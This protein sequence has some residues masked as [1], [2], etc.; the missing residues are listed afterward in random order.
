MDRSLSRIVL[1]VAFA[2][3][4]L[5]AQ[6]S[7]PTTTAI[8][9]VTVIDV[10]KG[11][12]RPALTVVVEGEK[13]ARI[14][15]VA[16]VRPPEGA[17]IVNG[18][19]MFLMPGLIDAHVHYVDP[20][21]FGPLHVANGVVL[22]R[23]M[24]ND[25]GTAIDLRERTRRH[26]L[27]GPELVVTGAIID[28][29][30]PVWP[31]SEACTTAE[32][33]RAAVR[34]LVGAGVDQLKVYSRL[35]RDA[36]FAILDEAKKLGKKAVGHVPDSVTLEEAVAAGQASLEHLIGFE[37]IF[38]RLAGAP[39]ATSF[40]MLFRQWEHYPKADR[41]ALAK[42][43]ED[44]RK[45]G[46]VICPTLVVMEGIVSMSDPK[47]ANDP[48]QAYIPKPLKAFWE[49]GGYRGMAAEV[50]RGSPM[51][52]AF[53]AELHKAGV[54]LVCGTD[55]ANPNVIA[56]FSLHREMQIFQ[57]A[58]IPS[59]AVLECATLESA[60]LLGVADRLG[61]IAER[62]TA[63]MVLVRKNPLENVD[64]AALI[65]GVFLRGRHYDRKA[66]DAMLADV[67][68]LVAG[69]VPESQ[70]ES[71][72]ASRA[73]PALPGRVIASGEY[74]ITFG[75]IPAG[76]ETF[77]VTE[78]ESGFFFWVSNETKGGYDVPSTTIVDYDRNLAFRKG[79]WRKETKTPLEARYALEGSVLQATARRS[80]KDLPPKSVDVPEGG[81]VVPPSTVCDFATLRSLHLEPGQKRAF[82]SVAFG[83]QDWVPQVMDT[84]VERLPDA[85]IDLPGRAG[86]KTT[87]YRSTHV[88][89]VGTFSSD[90]WLDA[91]GIPVKSVTKSPFGK[92]EAVL[93]Q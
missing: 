14:G 12:A 31:F 74:V 36:Y 60:R 34:K 3:G 38:A 80:D 33:G 20:D 85:S 53:I 25:T 5:I 77:K 26:E 17:R 73:A 61:S 70:P 68:A 18:G 67:R 13:I 45:S 59:A 83:F 78:D 41:A 86:V 27:F 7:G 44:V 11:E 88:T 62:H 58:G 39:A 29:D 52:E 37:R 64:N 42:I 51:R 91:I 23:E 46:C 57:Q 81:V 47:L 24:G 1:V 69:S 65:E 48:L 92:I 55:L 90:V 16:D 2:L 28:G 89:A 35:P 32:D 50:K 21:T 49:V 66:L 84:T 82:K 15:P 79:S 19:G 56:G 40:V 87:C 10:E 63:S 22:V 6:D 76:T 54:P 8:V 71:R 72:A 30:P 93:K 43:L 9:D 4:T 75:K